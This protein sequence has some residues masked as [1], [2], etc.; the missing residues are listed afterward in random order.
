MY[1]IVLTGPPGSGKSTL[2]NIFSSKHNYRTFDIIDFYSQNSDFS[3][4][5]R[6]NAYNNILAKINETMLSKNIIMVEGFFYDNNRLEL[7]KEICDKNNYRLILINLT[8]NPL[9]LIKRVKQ[10]DEKRIN[11]RITENQVLAFFEQFK[12]IKADITINTTDYTVFDVEKMIIHILI[13][14]DNCGD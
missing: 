1:C 11:S 14:G 10:R 13:K 7:I 8:A 2:L 5:E 6:I 4:Q 3:E 12:S 9:E